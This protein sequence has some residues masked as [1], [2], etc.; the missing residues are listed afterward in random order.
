MKL[1]RMIAA[2]GAALA[3]SACATAVPYNGGALDY[4]ARP[5]YGTV[6]LSSGYQPDPHVVALLAGGN[7]DASGLGAGCRGSITSAPDVRLV[8]SAST[9]LPL[10][11]SADSQSDTTLVINGPDGSW[12]CD[13]DGG[14][15]L[16]PSIRFSSPQTGRYEIWVGT[17]SS[18]AAQPA[19]LYISELTS[20]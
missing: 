18:G 20:Q 15:G 17:Y 4:N 7:I 5:N 16:N 1:T 8:Y 12:Y 9:I 6:T 19:R 13:D 14:D 10:I 2:I 3:L 11:I